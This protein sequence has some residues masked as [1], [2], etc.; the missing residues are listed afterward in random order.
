VEKL[1]SKEH[2]YLDEHEQVEGHVSNDNDGTI[3]GI[4][5]NMREAPILIHLFGLA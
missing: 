2:L 3:E 5:H 1:Y 4:I